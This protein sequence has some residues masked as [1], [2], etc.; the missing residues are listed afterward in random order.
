MRKRWMMR[1]RLPQENKKGAAETQL[2]LSVLVE[3]AVI[4][5]ASENLSSRLSTSVAD[6]FSLSSCAPV[7]KLAIGQFRYSRRATETL[8]RSRSLLNDALFRAAVL[9]GRTAAKIKQLLKQFYC[10]RLF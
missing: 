4:E 2:Y 9:P 6:S 1:F 8:T 7:G 5:T 10:C 3:M